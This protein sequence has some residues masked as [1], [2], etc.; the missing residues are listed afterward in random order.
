MAQLESDTP[1]MND[2]SELLAS[3]RDFKESNVFVFFSTEYDGLEDSKELNNEELL[4]SSKS[5]LSNF[6]PNLKES[7]NKKKNMNN[8]EIMANPVN[9]Q[10][11]KDK[12]ENND[13]SMKK[14]ITYTYEISKNHEK[15]SKQLDQ[16]T[17]DNKNQP[18]KSINANGIQNDK[19]SLE[20]KNLNSSLISKCDENIYT[21]PIIENHSESDLGTYKNTKSKSLIQTL[22]DK[23]SEIINE[24]NQRSQESYTSPPNINVKQT[25]NIEITKTEQSTNIIK[26]IEQLELEDKLGSQETCF[27][28][29]IINNEQ[30]EHLNS[31][32]VSSDMIPVTK[33]NEIQSSPKENNYGELNRPDIFIRKISSEMSFKEDN[34]EEDKK[35]V[36]DFNLTRTTIVPLWAEQIEFSKKEEHS[37]RILLHLLFFFNIFLLMFSI[38][39]LKMMNN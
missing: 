35:I 9:N 3:T 19:T 24:T 31:L 7:L 17:S 13:D 11:N 5:Y 29:P 2:K 6:Y 26:S 23:Q 32:Q 14:N 39:Q 8:E 15:N 34:I 20:C 22:Y 4:N 37:N 28:T 27:K 1:V 12:A 25:D 33:S 18:L 16:Q 10:D 38:T 36:Y 30:V 21:K